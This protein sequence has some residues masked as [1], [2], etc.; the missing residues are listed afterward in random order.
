MQVLPDRRRV[1]LATTGLLLS[2]RMSG[3]SS[4]TLPVARGTLEITIAPG[5]SLETEANIESWI[6]LAAQATATYY[7]QFPVARARLIVRTSPH[8]RGVWGG[9]TYG[10]SPPSIHVSIGEQTSRAQ[11]EDDWVL[12]HEMVHLAFPSLAQRHHWLEEGLATYVEPLARVQAGQLAAERFWREFMRDLPQG[13]PQPSDG[14]LDQTPTWARTYWGGALFCFWA[15]LTLRERTMNRHSL[16]T[17][18]Q[19]VL[20]GGGNV[21]TTW[22]LRAALHLADQE[23]GESVLTDLYEEWK[24]APVAPDLEAKWQELGLRKQ[25]RE[26]L[27]DDTAPLAGIRRALV[28]PALARNVSGGAAR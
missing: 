5:K 1:L 9:T 28:L 7:G 20:L 4:W 16:Q 27:F 21:S 15:D 14:G 19:A 6:S 12:T 18:L 2:H 17:A 13:L 8:R 24:S 26:V 11:L 23:S 3:Q 10:T 25:G 22:P